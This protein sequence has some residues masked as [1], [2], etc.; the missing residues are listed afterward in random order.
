MTAMAITL[1]TAA[2]LFLILLCVA[3]SHAAARGD[4][5]MRRA[6]AA[7]AGRRTAADRERRIMRV[8]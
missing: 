8:A 5:A 3:L 6:I 4:V 7:E 1:A 2:W